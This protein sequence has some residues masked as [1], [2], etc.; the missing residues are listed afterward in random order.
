MIRPHPLDTDLLR[1]SEGE[2]SRDE[3]M[4]RHPDHDLERSL[5]VHDLLIASAAEPVTVPE[6][7]AIAPSL[8]DEPSVAGRL[9]RRMFLLLLGGAIVAGPAVAEAVSPGVI[10]L[11]IIDPVADVLPFVERG[12]GA[13]EVIPADVEDGNDPPA[14]DDA[15]PGPDDARLP[16]DEPGP[17]EAP[18][19]NAPVDEAP[20]DRQAPEPDGESSPT[21]F[22]LR[23]F[24]FD[25][26][27]GPAVQ[28]RPVTDDR[29]AESTPREQPLADR[30]DDRPPTPTP[31]PTPAPTPTPPDDRPADRDPP[32]DGDPPGD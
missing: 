16:S 2:L 24:D 11:T 25:R 30:P 20:A 6:W 10:R 31:A 4:V 32:R 15:E 3:L 9:K 28:D 22:R 13:D 27:D 14:T 12:G 29:P 1:W 17:V 21:D 18:G 5:D 26:T 8:A 19:D 7:S 23:E